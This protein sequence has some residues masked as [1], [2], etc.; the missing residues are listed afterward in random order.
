MLT[1]AAVTML[2]PG[3]PLDAIWRV[4][5]G[6]YAR[7]LPHRVTVGL[8][9]LALAPLFAAASYGFW[10]L[11]GW[12]WHLA[13]GLFWLHLAG[14]LARL[15]LGEVLEGLVGVSASTLILLFLSR[16]EVR[17]RFGV[18]QSAR[19]APERGR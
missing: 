3:T 11:R 4:N 9:F 13:R 2:V 15:L 6:A 19:R 12:A 10:R 17:A 5:P 14:D 18:D 8:G 16:P 7:M 1:L